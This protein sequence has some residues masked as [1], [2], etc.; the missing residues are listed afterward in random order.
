[1]NN[2]IS[3]NRFFS[4]LININRVES[5]KI[6]YFR[7][8]GVYQDLMLRWNEPHRHFHNVKHLRDCLNVYDDYPCDYRKI[9]NPCIVEIA[10]W[11]HDAVYCPGSENNEEQSADMARRDLKYLGIADNVVDEVANS[12]M[13]TKYPIDFSTKSP[14][15]IRTILFDLI[16]S[17]NV[18]PNEFNENNKLIWKEFGL[19]VYEDG[20]PDVSYMVERAKILCSIMKSVDSISHYIDSYI[21]KHALFNNMHKNVNNFSLEVFNKCGICYRSKSKS[22][23]K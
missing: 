9:Q 19:E 11:Y 16:S 5:G 13:A 1:M 22:F 18:S 12:I 10:L 6:D 15:Q 4:A 23:N 8:N 2:I 20:N 7:V 17:L 3:P 14:D 21:P